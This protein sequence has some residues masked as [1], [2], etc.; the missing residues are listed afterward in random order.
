MATTRIPHHHRRHGQEVHLSFGWR[1]LLPSGELVLVS[2]TTVR[3]LPSRE[4]LLP[5]TFCSEGEAAVTVARLN[6]R[7]A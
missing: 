2:V 7:Q 5:R 6:G 1:R 4:T 3:G